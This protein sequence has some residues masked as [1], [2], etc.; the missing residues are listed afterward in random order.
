MRLITTFLAGL[1]A[2]SS[3]SFADIVQV[4]DKKPINIVLPVGEQRFITFPD[5]VAFGLPS[6]YQSTLSVQN[7]NKTLYIT[8]HKAFSNHQFKVKTAS[9]KMVLINLSAQKEASNEPVLIRY[10]NDGTSSVTKPSSNEQSNTF[11]AVQKTNISLTRLM[12]YSI[13]QYFA[14]ERLLQPVKGINLTQKFNGKTYNL[15]PTG[16]VTAIPLNSYQNNNL[17]VTAIYIQNNLAL[18]VSIDPE[19]LSQI[20]G[21]WSVVSVFPQSVLMPAGNEYDRSMLFL[22]SK[23]DFISQY[24]STCG[25]E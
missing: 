23:N 10:K 14:P 18:D 7:D 2:I 9:N 12:Q 25:L 13:Q 5:K 11:R 24:N 19:D 16:A 8:A 17:T 20:C 21:D 4:W 1:C 15:F 22:V 3:V 6:N